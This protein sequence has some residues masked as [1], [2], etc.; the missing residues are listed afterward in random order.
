MGEQHSNISAYGDHS[1]L[2]TKQNKTNKQKKNNQPTNHTNKQTKKK[3]NT[4]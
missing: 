3:P 1:H 2:K 4:L